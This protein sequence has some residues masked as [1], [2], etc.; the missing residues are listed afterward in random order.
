MSATRQ[1]I[2]NHPFKYGGR[3]LERGTVFEPAGGKFDDA[4]LDNPKY[5]T[6]EDVGDED[7]AGMT[8]REL[9]EALKDMGLPV[10]GRKSELIA[11]LRG[12]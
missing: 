8:V 9:R 11:R 6:W 3:R 7:Y 2:V 12:V 10:H 1:P 5:I 4:I